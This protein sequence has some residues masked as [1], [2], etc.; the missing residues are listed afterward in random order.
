MFDVAVIG[1]GPSGTAAAFVLLEKGLKVLLLDK[2][3]FPRKKACAGGITPKGYHLFPYDISSVVKKKCCAV[4][5]VGQNRR[6]FLIKDQN[7]ICY[8]TKREDLDLFSLNKVMEK[9]VK[10]KVIKEIRSICETPR[11]VEISA[12]KDTQGFAGRRVY[13]TWGHRYQKGGCAY[14]CR[15]KPGLVT[16]S[17]GKGISRRLV[18]SVKCDQY[19]DASITR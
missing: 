9:G 16:T 14:H 13:F 11:F 10:F 6:S 12:G 7:T 15:N 1:A 18:L 19:Q 5:I 2:Y 17:T 8:M 4:N 3:E